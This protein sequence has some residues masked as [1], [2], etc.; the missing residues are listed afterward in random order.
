M[1]TIDLSLLLTAVFFSIYGVFC[2]VESGVA[3][4]F[5]LGRQ[6]QT[7]RFFTP[8]WEVTNVFLVFGFTTVAMIFNNALQTLGHALFWTLAIGLLALLIRACTVLTLFYWRAD[9]LPKWG[10]WIFLITCL[11]IPLSFASAGAYLLTGQLFWHTFVGSLLVLAA[12]FGIVTIGLLLLNQAADKRRF[13]TNEVIFSS[14]LLVLGSAL[15]LA[16]AHGGDK[17]QQWPVLTISFLCIVGLFIALLTTNKLTD[18]KLWKYAVLLGL[19]SPVL[20]AWANR[21][22]LINGKIK[23]SDAFGAASYAHVYLIGSAI[24]FPLVALGF[25]LFFKLLR[26]P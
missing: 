24:I 11:T 25:W 6:A 1:T 13:L 19:I 9:S 14:W 22:Y 10:A 2:A 12:L 23:L 3:L 8:V 4:N 26:H 16:I 5:V 18:F 21:P 7:R 20:L 15:P 17:L